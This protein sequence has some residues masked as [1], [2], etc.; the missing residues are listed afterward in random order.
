MSLPRLRW[1]PLLTAGVFFSFVVFGFTDNLRG[2]TLPALLAER[3]LTYGQGGT[4]L[5]AGYAGFV[6]G[7]MSAGVL[8]DRIG[9]KRVLILASVLLALGSGSFSLLSTFAGLA[10]GS[11]LMGLGLGHFETGGNAFMVDLHPDQRGRYL[12]LLGMFH[13]LGSM[14][15]P[16]YAGALLAAGI[17]WRQVFQYALP[18]M[19]LLTIYLVLVKSPPHIA[20]ESRN[21]GA[22]RQGAPFRKYAWFFVLIAAYVGAEVGLASWLVEFLQ[23][24]KGQSVVVSSL[25][26]SI[27]FGGIMVGR[28]VGSFLV[29]RVGYLPFLLMVSGCATLT[30]GLGIFGPPALAFCLPLTGL[31]FAVIFP[32]AT[33]AV[34]ER[35]GEHSGVI[36]GLLFTCGGLGAMIGPWLIGL[37]SDW[38]GLQLGFGVLVG[39]CLLITVSALVLMGAKKPVPAPELAA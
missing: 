17:A 27:F 16:L 29:E 10:A 35:A 5:F 12:N 13:S 21:G 32:T 26:L 3:H 28:L 15:V 23:K 38:F 7:T 37:C 39:Y 19:V 30:A 6:A 9:K 34:S 2:P 4:I 36:L 11:A 33:A 20:G 1:L 18:L 22:Q 14:I 25:S 24:T 31:F 8:A